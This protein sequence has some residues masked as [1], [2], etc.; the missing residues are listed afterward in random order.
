MKKICL[1]LASGVI[2]GSAFAQ[3]AASAADV[4][5]AAVDAPNLTYCYYAGKP[6][7][8]GAKRGDQ[9]C[10]EDGIQ[11]YE[12]PANGGPAVKQA[13]PPHWEPVRKRPQMKAG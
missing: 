6:Y 12:A 13:D 7:S 1:F 3:T 5:K 8:I 4:A 9:V 10:T 2:A 11:A